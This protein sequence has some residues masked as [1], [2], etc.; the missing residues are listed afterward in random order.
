M[1]MMDNEPFCGRVDDWSQDSCWNM[2]LWRKINSLSWNPSTMLDYFIEKK[3]HMTSATLCW[4]VAYSIQCFWLYLFEILTC[5][6]VYCHEKQLLHLY[7][8]S[9]HFYTHET[10]KFFCMTFF[11]GHTRLIALYTKLWSWQISRQLV[12]NCQLKSIWTNASPNLRFKSHYL[13]TMYTRILGEAFS[14]SFKHGQLLSNNY[15]SDLDVDCMTSMV[16]M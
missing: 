1:R 4:I 12:I 15:E 5:S 10:H 7:L 8:S 14:Q 13:H 6:Y 2:T 3:Y 16:M 11:L 9:Y